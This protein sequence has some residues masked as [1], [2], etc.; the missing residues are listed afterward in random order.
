MVNWGLRCC[1]AMKDTPFLSSSSLAPEEPAG[2]QGREG[3]FIS[4]PGRFLGERLCCDSI[5]TP[6]GFPALRCLGLSVLADIPS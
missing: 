6:Q 1:R 2:V 4:S 5:C 3:P